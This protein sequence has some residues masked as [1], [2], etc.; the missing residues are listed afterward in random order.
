VPTLSR[1]L[2]HPDDAIAGEAAYGEWMSESQA[3]VRPEIEREWRAAALRDP[4]EYHQAV[5]LKANPGLSHDWLLFRIQ[6]GERLWFFDSRDPTAVALDALNRD[7]R[8]SITTLL[9]NEIADPMVVAR[10]IGDDAAL[11]C[12]LLRIESLSWVHTAPLMGELNAAWSEKA[13]VALDHGMIPEAIAAATQMQFGVFMGNHSS[14]LAERLAELERFAVDQDPGL[15]R[16]LE[17]AVDRHKASLA[18]QLAAEHHEAVH[19]LR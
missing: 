3:T 1:L 15:T 18:R 12:E 8:R 9:R 16:V 17:I 2:Q 4:E 5:I 10:L 7:E 19:G 13:R 14:V 6:A 11:Y